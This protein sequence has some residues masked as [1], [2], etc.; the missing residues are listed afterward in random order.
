MILLPHRLFDQPGIGTLLRADAG[1]ILTKSLPASL[2][3]REGYVSGH[4]LSLVQGGTQVLRDR[5][6]RTYTVARGQLV[7]LPRDL[8]YITDLVAAHGSTFES[9]VVFLH[10]EAIAAFMASHRQPASS[11]DE[12]QPQVHTIPTTVQHYLDSLTALYAH[13]DPTDTAPLLVHK[14]V[15]LLQLLQLSG[16]EVATW[17][18]CAEAP[19]RR[20]LARFMERHFDKPLTVEDYAYL[21]G[22]SVTSFR[23]A[24]KATYDTTPHQWLVQR[25][26]ERAEMYLRQHNWSVARVAQA[27][28]YE[29]TSHFIKQFKGYAGISPGQLAAR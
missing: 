25:R 20:H 22:R 14:Q 11:L 5:E 19:R 16:I 1:A 26:M 21:T 24:F 15:E 17:L 13:L 2:P 7:L 3:A 9:V 10:R 27:V 29:S 12:R 28:G 4:T 23:R 6:G 18:L 8:Y